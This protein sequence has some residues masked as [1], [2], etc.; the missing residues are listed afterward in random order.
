MRE[1]VRTH[2]ARKK[3]SLEDGLRAA[4]NLLLDEAKARC[5]VD[6]GELRD[7]AFLEIR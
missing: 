4:G 1:T 6:T 7:S 3:R 5:P 2:L